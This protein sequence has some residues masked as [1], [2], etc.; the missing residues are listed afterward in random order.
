LPLWAAVKRPLPSS[1]LPCLL[2]LPPANLAVFLPADFCGLPYRLS[3]NEPLF[4][5]FLRGFLGFS[6]LRHHWPPSKV[7]EAKHEA[8]PYCDGLFNR[9]NKPRR[10]EFLRLSTR[11]AS[12][13]EEKSAFNL[14][15]SPRKIFQEDYT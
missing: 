13:P 11:G 6:L 8:R 4:L 3:F 1:A 9:R 15:R 7:K 12:G 10:I 14:S 2:Q 5:L